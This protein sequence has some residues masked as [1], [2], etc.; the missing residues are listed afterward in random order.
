MQKGARQKFFSYSLKNKEE[1]G[2]F[3]RKKK[4]GN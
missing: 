3:V 4:G 2:K 1:V